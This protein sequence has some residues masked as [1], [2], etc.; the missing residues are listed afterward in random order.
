MAEMNETINAG[1][2]LRNERAEGKE[3]EHHMELNSEENI[4]TKSNH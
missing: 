1:N 3:E 4:A 2:E